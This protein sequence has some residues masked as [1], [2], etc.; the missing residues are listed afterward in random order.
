MDKLVHKPDG[1]LEVNDPYKQLGAKLAYRTQIE[2]RIVL[3]VVTEAALMRYE[4]M[5]KALEEFDPIFAEWEPYHNGL[6][7]SLGYMP[8]ENVWIIHE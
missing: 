5:N 2:D 3:G 4:R 1:S 7:P 6:V 8:R